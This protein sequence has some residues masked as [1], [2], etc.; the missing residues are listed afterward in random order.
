MLVSIFTPAY[1][2]DYL[3]D[4]LYKSLL[5][6]SVKNFEWIIVDDGSTDSTHEIISKF[7]NEGKISIKYYKQNNSGKHIA[8]NKGIELANGELF[9][10]VDSDDYLTED[11]IEFINEKYVLIKED[12]NIAGF[13]A[14]KGYSKSKKIGSNIEYESLN[15]NLK[16]FRFKLKIKGDMAEVIKLDVIKEFPFPEIKNE[17]F[18][19]EGLIWFRIS[20]KYNFIWFSKIIYIA[21]YLEGG[22]SANSIKLRKNSP[23][24]TTLL[25]SE[26]SKMRLPIFYKLK[27]NVNYWRFAKY[28][29]NDFFTL[30]KKV[31]FLYSLL[32]IP[33]SLIYQLK[34]KS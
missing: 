3:L 11:A 1:N 2:R 14:R 28:C 12:D 33:I 25:Y 31:D 7:I 18:C 22:L 19:S 13:S 15:M 16:D 24:Y 26:L 23:E 17:K 8:I 20:E 9:F 27:Y 21:E 6:Q 32:G 30:F 10:I 34:D 29:K 5:N 4:R